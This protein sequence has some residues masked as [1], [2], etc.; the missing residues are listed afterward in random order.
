MSSVG[1]VVHLNFFRQ[2]NMAL[3]N[4]DNNDFAMFLN[5]QLDS[6]AYA[7]SASFQEADMTT[8][9]GAIN[10]MDTSV[11]FSWSVN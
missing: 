2:V 7:V 9:K 1:G 8:V 4:D 10:Y 11:R 5:G 3:Q 6:D